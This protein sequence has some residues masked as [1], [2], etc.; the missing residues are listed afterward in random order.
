MSPYRSQS[1]DEAHD[2]AGFESGQPALDEWLKREALRAQRQDTARTYVWT[3]PAEPKVVAY[4]SV[5]PTEVRRDDVSRSMSGGLSTVPAFLLARL[6]LDQS[7]QG[8]GLGS[9]LLL[10]ALEVIVRAST[11]ASG[12]LIVVDA[13]DDVA[14]AFYRHHNFCPVEGGNRLV[15]KVATARAALGL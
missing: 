10:D 3:E 14:H 1:L 8:R 11:M 6:A 2:L 13:I 7:L 15:M 4:Y 5:V 12:R 9:Q